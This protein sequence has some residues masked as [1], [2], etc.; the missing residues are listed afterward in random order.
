MNGFVTIALPGF[1][2]ELTEHGEGIFRVTYAGKSADLSSRPGGLLLES[3]PL[4]IIYEHLTSHERLTKL[5]D[6]G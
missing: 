1:R 3:S 5:V 6:R 2:L 4:P